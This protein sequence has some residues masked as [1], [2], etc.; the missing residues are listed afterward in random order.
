MAKNDQ[1]VPGNE[2]NKVYKDLLQKKKQADEMWERVKDD[3][4]YIGSAIAVSNEVEWALLK[5]EWK[6]RD[7]KILKDYP[8]YDPEDPINLKAEETRLNWIRELERETGK[9][10][11]QIFGRKPTNQFTGGPCSPRK[12]IDY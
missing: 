5:E 10:L 11:E 12:S 9:T 6:R 1:R 7:E 3:P 4:T 2:V 8:D